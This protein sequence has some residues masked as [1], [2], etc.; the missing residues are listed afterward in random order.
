MKVKEESEKVALKLNIQETKIMASGP[1]TSWQI[2]GETVAEFI[3]LGSKIT[4]DGDCSHEIK[5]RL[6][7]G[8]KVMTNLDIVLKSRDI[9]LPAKVHL[10]KAMVFPVVMYGC[11]KW[12]IKKAECRRIDA[13]ELWCWRGLLRVPWTARRSSQ[14]ILKEISPGCSLEGLMSEL[15]LQYFGHLMWRADSLEKTLMLGKMEGRRRRG[16][17]RMRCLDGITDSMN[18][19][20][21]GLWELVMDREAWCAAVHGVTKSQT[22]LTT[23]LNWAE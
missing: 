21:G 3:F 14:S 16:Q 6:L 15:K 1:I 19:G 13:F 7:L 4:T 8:R 12:T 20:L 9:T 18:M 2:D 11:E 23:E 22:R 5:R 10:V 17:Q